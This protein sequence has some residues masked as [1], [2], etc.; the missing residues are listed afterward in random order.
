MVANGKAGALTLD[1]QR[2]P[3]LDALGD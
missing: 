2:P 3:G 1:Y